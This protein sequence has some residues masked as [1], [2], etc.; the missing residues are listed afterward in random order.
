MVL[1]A[2]CSSD[3]EEPHCEPIIQ[4][5]I[6]ASIDG[7]PFELKCGVA[8]AGGSESGAT[9]YA[10]APKGMTVRLSN[11]PIDCSSN[12]SNAG[13][14]QGKHVYTAVWARVPG[15]YDVAE[16]MIWDVAGKYA[17][18]YPDFSST[19]VIDDVTETSVT[20]S[21]DVHYYTTASAVG[22]FEVKRC[23]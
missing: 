4:N 8:T 10:D 22:S 23:F 16:A 6:S 19:T 18:G 2:G 11:A 5:G 7:K 1:C 3:A 15:T 12:L 13:S 9:V 17:T 20:G 14:L 21:I